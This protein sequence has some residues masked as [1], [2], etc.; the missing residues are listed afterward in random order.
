MKLT[1][2]FHRFRL[3]SEKPWVERE[4]VRQDVLAQLRTHT[5]FPAL[6]D[7]FD[8]ECVTLWEQFIQTEPTERE[9]LRDL[10]AQ[11]RAIYRMI[12]LIDQTTTARDEAIKVEQAHAELERMHSAHKVDREARRAALGADIARR[13]TQRDLTLTGRAQEG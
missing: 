3:G 11:A 9:K 8:S 1:E 13:R 2:F 4:V 7:V 6:L 10:H 5:G 12:R